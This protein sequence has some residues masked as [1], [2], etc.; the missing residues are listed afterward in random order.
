ME[1]QDQVTKVKYFKFTPQIVSESVV[2][3]SVVKSDPFWM[4]KMDLWDFK[5]DL[6][7]IIWISFNIQ[8]PNWP[9]FLA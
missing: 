8:Y 7:F 4:S 2:R 6:L 5:S 3:E 1:W 9:F